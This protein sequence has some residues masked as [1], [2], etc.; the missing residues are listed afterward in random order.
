MDKELVEKCVSDMV[1][2]ISFAEDYIG[3]Q[4]SKEEIARGTTIYVNL[5]WKQITEW[6]DLTNDPPKYN[7]KE[8]RVLL[9]HIMGGYEVG[10]ITTYH[11]AMGYKN[12]GYAQWKHIE[13]DFDIKD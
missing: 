13:I 8:Y 5:L 12:K 4:L 7:G 10:V 2:S 9:K 11:S 1:E 6:R 3:V